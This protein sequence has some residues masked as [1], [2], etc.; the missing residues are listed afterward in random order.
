VTD[1]DPEP[2]S[3][4]S[5]RVFAGDCTTAF[6]GGRDR[7][8]RGRVVIVIKPDRTVLVHDAA[9][10]QPVAWLT[11]ADSLTVETAARG[12]GPDGG[13]DRHGG[14]DD[15][16]DDQWDDAADRRVPDPPS[17]GVGIVA[18]SGEE[19]LRVVSHGPAARV[20]Y[21]VSAAGV[22][23]GDCP[24]C[25]GT[26]VRNGGVTCLD[27]P[28]E[29]AL[30]AGATVL[31]ARCDDCGA[32]LMRVERGATFVCCVDVGCQAL[33]DLVA[34]RFDRSFD[35]PACGRDL[36]V[37]RARGRIFLGCAGYPDCEATV[38]VPAGRFVDECDCGLPVVETATGRRCLDTDC[39]RTDGR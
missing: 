23:V 14:D 27:C 12:A 5:I 21:P 30:P 9:G 37:K 4:E 10:F 26:L 15:P 2:T 1:S 36:R 19:R 17:G 28:V 33:G 38:S 24:E 3:G 7:T 20:R 8:R 32:P 31:D 35:C 18:R 6:T 34:E 13:S 29:H 11:R 16:T 25:D 22:P 39:D